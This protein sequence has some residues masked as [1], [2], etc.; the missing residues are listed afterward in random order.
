MKEI[1][2]DSLDQS[3]CKIA[4]EWPFIY[5]CLLILDPSTFNNSKIFEIPWHP[6]AINLESGENLISY[7]H[8]S[9]AAAPFLAWFNLKGYPLYYWYKL[10]FSS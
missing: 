7:T 5:L 10:S 9:I 4:E 8:P 1:L 6:Y 2:S 3:M